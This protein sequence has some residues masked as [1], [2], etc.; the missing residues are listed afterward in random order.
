MI[1]RL[2]P[3]IG[4]LACGAGPRHSFSTTTP[5]PEFRPPP[6]PQATVTAPPGYTTAPTPDNDATGPQSRASRNASVAP[7]LFARSDQYRGQGLSASSSAQTGQDR[8][9]KP[10]AGLKLSMPLQ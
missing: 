9:A 1:R 4:L 7:G 6:R 2:L 3:L 5:M 8:R 10:G